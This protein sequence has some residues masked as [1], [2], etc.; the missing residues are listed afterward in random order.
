MA[1]SRLFYVHPTL[2][3]TRADPL[4]HHESV[5]RRWV[6]LKQNFLL[7]ATA[8]E[9]ESK[10]PSMLFIVSRLELRVARPTILRLV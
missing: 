6:V 5:S 4:S 10:A 7:D 9:L 3:V 2:L 8:K 1:F